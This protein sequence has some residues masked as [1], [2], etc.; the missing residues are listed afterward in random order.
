MHWSSFL[1]NCNAFGS[2]EEIHLTKRNRTDMRYSYCKDFPMTINPDM[3]HILLSKVSLNPSLYRPQIFWDL[4][5][6]HLIDTRILKCD[7]FFVVWRCVCGHT[8]WTTLMIP[9]VKS[10]IF[11]AVTRKNSCMMFALDVCCVWMLI[12][13][14]HLHKA[15]STG[16]MS[17]ETLKAWPVNL[18]GL[19]AAGGWRWEGKKLKSVCHRFEWRLLYFTEEAGRKEIKLLEPMS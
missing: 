17:H 11:L 10:C 13:C 19:M 18:M 9:T 6:S 3:C 4:P 8:I 5:C 15:L 14:E 2:L 16:K 7:L 12:F 1:C